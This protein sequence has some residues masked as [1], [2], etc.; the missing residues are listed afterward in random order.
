MT[1]FG[2]IEE[3]M[4]RLKS[5]FL[6]GL[7]AC[8]IVACGPSQDTAE[9]PTEAPEAADLAQPAFEDVVAEPVEPEDF[10]YDPALA[11]LF[12]SPEFAVIIE[13]ADPTGPILFAD[14]SP[15]LMP[16]DRQGWDRLEFVKKG[17][18]AIVQ[19]AALH[20]SGAFA[21][22]T[23]RN[24]FW[25][26]DGACICAGNSDCNHM[27]STVCRDPATG[28]SCFHTGSMPICVCTLN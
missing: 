27:F 24:G 23:M 22:A 16:A 9:A 12:E 5:T 11:Q 10:D 28:G 14:A 19:I 2:G 13:V 1:A 26:S 4:G 18:E 15:P 6:T 8:F 3:T 21:E 25:C 17:P 20:K 7:I